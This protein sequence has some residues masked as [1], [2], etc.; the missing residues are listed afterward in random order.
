MCL[1]DFV[2]NPA[3]LLFQAIKCYLCPRARIHTHLDENETQTEFE[4][5]NDT[6]SEF[7]D[8]NDTP[9]HVRGPAMNFTL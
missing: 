8:Q 3:D 5:R 1:G 7:W 6:L 2:S 4:D 9:L